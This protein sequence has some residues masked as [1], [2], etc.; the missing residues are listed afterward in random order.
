MRKNR[1]T[2]GKKKTNWM[3][4]RKMKRK[5]RREWKRRR[6]LKKMMRGKDAFWSTMVVCPA[7]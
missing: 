7:T 5:K 4:K 2:E 3:K 1:K 6:W